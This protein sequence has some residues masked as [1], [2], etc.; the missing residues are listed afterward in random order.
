MKGLREK[1]QKNG[2]FTL[3]EMLIVVAIIAILIAVSIPLV[4][5]SLDKTR[6]VT[7]DANLRAAKAE[8]MVIYLDNQTLDTPKTVSEL[9]SAYM[10]YNIESGKLV[11]EANQP[12]GYNKYASTGGASKANT[13]VIKVVFHEITDSADE[14]VTV[15]WE[16]GKTTP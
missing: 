13:K 14:A 4:T 6:K 1:F 9:N 16:D 7:D 3:V 10:Y 12:S 8:A 2:G 11:P 15:S 5:T